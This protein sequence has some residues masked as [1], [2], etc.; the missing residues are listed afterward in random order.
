VGKREVGREEVLCTPFRIVEVR[1]DCAYNS[2]YLVLAL[3]SGVTHE[4]SSKGV[5]AAHPVVRKH[6]CNKC[7]K[8]CRDGFEE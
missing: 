8:D 5:F 3:S 1:K 2:V 6:L 4:S 7:R